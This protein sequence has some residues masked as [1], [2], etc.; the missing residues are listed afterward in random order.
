[1]FNNSL[2]LNQPLEDL[3]SSYYEYIDSFEDAEE[4]EF[5]KAVST[6]EFIDLKGYLIHM[7]V[8]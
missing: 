5:I 6:E 2:D 4:A 8:I 7:D 1:M 3:I